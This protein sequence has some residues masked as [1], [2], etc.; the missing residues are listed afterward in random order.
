MEVMELREA[1]DGPAATPRGSAPLR[2]Q[3]QAHIDAEERSPRD[4]LD[5]DAV[6]APS[7]AAR[8]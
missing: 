5:G 2:A 4:G 8:P 7:A 6:D 1:L 3:V